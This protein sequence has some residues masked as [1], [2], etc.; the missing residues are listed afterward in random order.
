MYALFS[1]VQTLHAEAIPE[2]F[3]VPTDD[4]VFRKFFDE[5][6]GSEEHFLAFA[7]LDDQPVGYIQYSLSERP[8]NTHQRARNFAYIHQLVV[9]KGQRRKGYGGALIEFAKKRAR[10]Q[11]IREVGIDFWSFNDA[12]RG[13]FERQGFQVRHEGMWLFE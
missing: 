3:R 11:G 5:V 4:D 10:E 6:D 2:I 13:C 7:S 8:R 1:E 9:T 12:A